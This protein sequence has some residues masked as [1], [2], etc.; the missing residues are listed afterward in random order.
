MPAPL[1]PSVTAAEVLPP[2]PDGTATGAPA[3][4]RGGAE[5]EAEEEGQRATPGAVEDLAGPRS[6]ALIVRRV[7]PRVAEAAEY[8]NNLG[9]VAW[10]HVGERRADGAA[11]W[12]RQC[13]GVRSMPRR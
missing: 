13:P 3:C 8:G 10:G 2:V 11:G 6:R 12:E 9:T 4:C 7:F 5:A 1:P